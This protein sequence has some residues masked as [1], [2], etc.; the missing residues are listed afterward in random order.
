MC[1]NRECIGEC[2]CVVLMWAFNSSMLILAFYFK[3]NSLPAFKSF[4]GR[5]HTNVFTHL[6]ATILQRLLVDCIII[7]SGK[8]LCLRAGPTEATFYTFG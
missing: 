2:R 6:R 3:V 4:S 8:T 7:P 1:L 5:K